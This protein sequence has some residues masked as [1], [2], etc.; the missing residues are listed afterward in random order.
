MVRNFRQ[1]NLLPWRPI[2][3]WL[4]NAGPRFNWFRLRGVF[5]WA[6]ADYDDAGLVDQDF[7]DVQEQGF[8]GRVQAELTPRIGAVVQATVDERD[9]RNSP[10][11]NS[12]GDTLLAGI[13]VDFT[14]LM[15]GELTL[16]RFEREYDSGASVDGTAIA[17]A[18]EWYITR[19]TTVNLSARRSGEDSGATA[20]SPYVANAYGMRVDHELRRNI[21]LSADVQTGSR[22][23]RLLDREDNYAS[24]Q[25]GAEYLLNRRIAFRA[26]LAHDET[27]SD[28]VDRY[29]DFE[30][31]V[32]SV[33]VSFRL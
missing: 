16:G 6:E 32:V 11:L 18:L 22:D 30:V 17:G 4:K 33:G 23:Y 27:E 24:A 29:R 21:I 13:A 19:L 12:E 7:R 14:E 20:A 5:N 15:R 8:T 3:A 2:R 25:L 1:P 26:S 9:Y 31:N 10:G 28:G